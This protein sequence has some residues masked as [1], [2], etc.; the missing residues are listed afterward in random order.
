MS[1][2]R[3]REPG[4]VLFRIKRG[5]SGYVSF[6]AACEMNQ[7]FSEYVL[8]EPILRILTARGYTVHCE[9]E[10]PGIEHALVGDKKRIDFVASRGDVYFALEVKW[11]QNDK[12]NIK[13]DLEKLRAFKNV[14]DGPNSHS[15]LCV[16]G[17]KRF[18][19]VQHHLHDRFKEIGDAVYA[20]FKTTRY[21]CRMFELKAR[22][23][24]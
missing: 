17:R 16:F 12:V 5:V 23:Y 9:V 7:A 4:D 22:R 13:G 15:F 18:V 21:G 8:Y 11:A 2:I 6:L 20:D 24:L 1:K 14:H 10:C 3:F 19:A